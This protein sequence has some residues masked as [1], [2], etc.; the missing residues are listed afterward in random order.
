[1]QFILHTAES[2]FHDHLPANKMGL[3]SAWIHR[4]AGR[5][6]HGATFPPESM[7]KYT[8]RFNSLGEMAKAH[9]LL[10]QH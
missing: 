6:G 2:L 3:A 10:L 1:M 4:R 5:S 7:P 9:Q 8:F